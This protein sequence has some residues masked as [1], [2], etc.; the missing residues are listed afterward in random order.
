MTEETEAQEGETNPAGARH[1]AESR[2][3]SWDQHRHSV[4]EEE[5]VAFFPPFQQQREGQ[6]GR[7]M[8][9]WIDPD[10]G[11]GRESKVSYGH[12]TPQSLQLGGYLHSQNKREV[13]KRFR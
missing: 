5:V 10:G 12:N 1:W 8:R 4:E 2:R 9:D 11:G 7:T 3:E 13:H 6:Q